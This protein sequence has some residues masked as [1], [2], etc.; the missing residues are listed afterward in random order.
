VSVHVV[1]DAASFR[2]AIETPFEESGLRIR[3]ISVAPAFAG[4][5]AERVVILDGSSGMVAQGNGK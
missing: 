5:L 4:S 2:T 3:N 1:D